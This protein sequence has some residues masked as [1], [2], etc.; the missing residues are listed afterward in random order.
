MPSRIRQRARRFSLVKLLHPTSH[1]AWF[2]HLIHANKN[3]ICV[4]I[5]ICVISIT[6]THTHT[7]CTSKCTTAQTWRQFSGVV[8]DGVSMVMLCVCTCFSNASCA[9]YLICIPTTQQ[10]KLTRISHSGRIGSLFLAHSHT[11]SHTHTHTCEYTHTVM[12]TTTTIK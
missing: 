1:H 3:W 2:K 4:V 6:H 10:T 11:Y 9:D 7:L 12:Q 8:K 5:S